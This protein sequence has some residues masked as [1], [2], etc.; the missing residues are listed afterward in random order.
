MSLR[1]SSTVSKKRKPLKRNLQAEKRKRSRMVAL[2]VAFARLR[3]LLP[4]TNPPKNRMSEIEILQQTLRYI[5]FLNR[6]L[7]K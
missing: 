6:M 1:H 5:I 3:R 4:P 2:H 7:C